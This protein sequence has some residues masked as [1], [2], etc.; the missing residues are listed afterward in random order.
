MRWHAV[1]R[2]LQVFAIGIVHLGNAGTVIEHAAERRRARLSVQHAAGRMRERRGIDLPLL[3]A[4]R[5]GDN[6]SRNDNDETDNNPPEH[7]ASP[8]STTKM[9]HT[10]K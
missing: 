6:C 1:D 3:R 9:M 5:S 8:Q 4:S 7:E 2:Q 10:Q